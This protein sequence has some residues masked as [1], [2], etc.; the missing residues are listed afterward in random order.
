M[1]LVVSASLLC[2]FD[3]NFCVL[4]PLQSLFLLKIDS[5]LL[6][7]MVSQ[8]TYITQTTMPLQLSCRQAQLGSECHYTALLIFEGCVLIL[9]KGQVN[10]S[11]CASLLIWPLLL[12]DH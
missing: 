11:A 12:S 8:H 4:F 6:L 2:T 3:A 9:C 7:K 10:A 1:Y 5:Q